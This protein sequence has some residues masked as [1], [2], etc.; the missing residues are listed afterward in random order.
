MSQAAFASATQDI[1]SWALQFVCVWVLGLVLGWLVSVAAP[2]AVAQQPLNR[3][4]ADGPVTLSCLQLPKPKWLDRGLK[5]KA[6][7]L[8]TPPGL[9]FRRAALAAHATLIVR[10]GAAPAPSF[11][12]L[13][14]RTFLP[15]SSL[16]AFC[17]NSCPFGLCLSLAA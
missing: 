17:S 6:L 8:S 16:A 10:C 12:H 3:A 9:W 15:A 14:S 11:Q 1:Q 4:P 7:L 2:V 13:P 5:A